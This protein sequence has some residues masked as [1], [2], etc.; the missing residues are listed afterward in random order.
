MTGDLNERGLKDTR[1]RVKGD[2]KKKR[3]TK[4][5]KFSDEIYKVYNYKTVNICNFDTRGSYTI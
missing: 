2:S 5:P 1:N 3:M 4:R